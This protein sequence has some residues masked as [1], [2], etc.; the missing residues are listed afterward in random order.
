[1]AEGGP[2]ILDTCALQVN[3]LPVVTADE[4]FEEYGLTVLS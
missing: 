1:M 3:D 4:R 2:M